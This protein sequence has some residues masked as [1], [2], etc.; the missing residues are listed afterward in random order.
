MSQKDFPNVQDSNKVVQKHKCHIDEGGT[1]KEVIVGEAWFFGRILEK[2]VVWGK[3]LTLGQ[4]FIRGNHLESQ[5][6]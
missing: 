5:E 1:N 4:K 2:S 3:D 6:T